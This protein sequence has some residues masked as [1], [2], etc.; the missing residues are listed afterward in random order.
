MLISGEPSLIDRSWSRR[1]V[2]SSYLLSTVP[3]AVVTW[4]QS[5]RR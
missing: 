5:R 1:M 4:I 3:M 2:L